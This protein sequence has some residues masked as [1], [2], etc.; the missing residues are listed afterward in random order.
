MHTCTSADA[1][2]HSAYAHVTYNNTYMHI[3]VYICMYVCTYVRTYVRMYACMHACTYKSMYS[4]ASAMRKF[5]SEHPA[6]TALGV[7]KPGHTLHLI[8][9]TG[10]SCIGAGSA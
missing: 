9:E 3:C 6:S 4:C 5:V 7:S 2:K 10:W 8:C 1:E